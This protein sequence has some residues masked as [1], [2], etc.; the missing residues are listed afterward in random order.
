MEEGLMGSMEDIGSGIKTRL[1]TISDFAKV[2][3]PNELPDSVNSFPTALVLPGETDYDATYGNA[4]Q[5][6]RFRVLILMSGA[7]QPSKLNRLCDY[8]DIDGS[9]SV[10]TA[11]AGDETLGSTC[12]SAKV[13]SN[14]G[15]GNVMWGGHIFMSTEFQIEVFG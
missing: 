1:Q 10:Y 5:D 14:S 2:F 12:D 3:A 4:T 9:D 6:Y 7:D 13:V 8:V 11:I 15:V